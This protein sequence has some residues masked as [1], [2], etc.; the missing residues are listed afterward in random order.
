MKE[1][2]TERVVLYYDNTSATNIS[3]NLVMHTKTNTLQS[4]IITRES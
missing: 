3:K 2:I 1:E 4:S